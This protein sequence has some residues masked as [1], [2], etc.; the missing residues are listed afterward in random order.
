[1][2]DSW[3]RAIQLRRALLVVAAVAILALLV[4][5]ARVVALLDMLMPLS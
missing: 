1:M 5:V 2:K 3:L 4:I